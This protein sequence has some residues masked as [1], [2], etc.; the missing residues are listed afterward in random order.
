MATI[1]PRWE[2]RTF[3]GGLRKAEEVLARHRSGADQESDELYLLTQAGENVKV[4]DDLMDIKVLRE[5][6]ANG[7]EQWFPV[8]KAAFPMPAA[9]VA[10][11]FEAL[12]VS[13]RRRAARPTRSPISQAELAG[14]RAAVRPVKVHKLRRAG[15]VRE[16]HGRV[17]RRHGGRATR[18]RRSPSRAKTPRP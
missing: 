6:N 18:E 1:I 3:D 11:V 5:V 12:R 7:L 16:L 15:Q 8:M 13:R 2:W 10:K 4:R 14:A 9:D 17:L